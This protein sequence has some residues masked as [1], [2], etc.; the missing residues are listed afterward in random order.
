MKLCSYNSPC[1]IDGAKVCQKR[2]NTHRVDI[3]TPT[4][5]F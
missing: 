5:D 3:V 4:N 1:Y 2:L